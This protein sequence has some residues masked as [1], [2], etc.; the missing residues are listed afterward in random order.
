MRLKM[1]ALFV[2][3]I[4]L[5]LLILL[6]INFSFDLNQVRSSQR[7]SSKIVFE[8]HFKQHRQQNTLTQRKNNNIQQMT[9]EHAVL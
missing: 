4:L 6:S 5:T 1:C 9:K 3:F 2:N 8:S 7:M